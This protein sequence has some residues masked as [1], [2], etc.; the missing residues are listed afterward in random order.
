MAIRVPIF[1]LLTSTNF[2][3]GGGLVVWR[4]A[5]SLRMMV[6]R[7]AALK[8]CA[9]QNPAQPKI[10][11]D[12]EIWGCRLKPKG[13]GTVESHPFDSAQGRLFRKVRGRMGHP[14][15]ESSFSHRIPI[16]GFETRDT[17]HE[18]PLNPYQLRLSLRPQTD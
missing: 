16:G 10:T 6:G 8:H 5:S 7:N 13:D 9:T 14:R 15:S 3:S 12:I 2:A 1:G 18:L 4:S 17:V 11:C